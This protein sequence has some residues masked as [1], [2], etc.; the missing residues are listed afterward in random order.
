[1]RLQT[2]YRR[3]RWCWKSFQ[4]ISKPWPQCLL[5]RRTD[6]ITT[7][8]LIVALSSVWKVLSFRSYKYQQGPL[9]RG[10]VSPVCFSYFRR[11]HH[12][13]KVSKGRKHAEIQHQLQLGSRPRDPEEIRR[14]FV[15]GHFK[16][17]TRKEDEPGLVHQ[18]ANR[19][20]V[21]VSVFEGR[22]LWAVEGSLQWL[23][24]RQLAK[25]SHLLQAL[26]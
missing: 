14:N 21:R 3:R 20:W 24:V 26:C 15:R 11:I 5:R 16:D 17:A 23:H 7:Q 8:D 2:C 4:P 19:E 9:E 12:Q 1:M 25:A 18:A 6:P 13:N 22:C 10:T